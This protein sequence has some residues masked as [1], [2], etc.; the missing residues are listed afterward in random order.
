MNY[1]LIFPRK[2]YENH[3]ALAGSFTKEELDTAEN[4][5]NWFIKTINHVDYHIEKYLNN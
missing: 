3:S 2:A 5:D 4:T 1:F